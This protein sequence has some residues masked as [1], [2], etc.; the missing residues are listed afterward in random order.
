V[1]SH[2]QLTATFTFQ[3]DNQAQHVFSSF[4]LTRIQRVLRSKQSLQTFPTTSVTF[5][6]MLQEIIEKTEGWTA[7]TTNRRKR[8]HKIDTLKQLTQQKTLSF[9]TF[10]M[11]IQHKNNTQTTSL[12]MLTRLYLC[13]SKS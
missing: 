7:K 2:L 8:G 6:V 10:C 13:P 1:L 3:R 5:L 11:N 9:R 4:F 12:I